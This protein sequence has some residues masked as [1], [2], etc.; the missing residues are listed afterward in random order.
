MDTTVITTGDD[1]PE[2]IDEAAPIVIEAPT[3][4]EIAADL[5]RTVAIIDAQAEA[6]VATIEAEG[7]A[8]VAIIEA[9]A[10]A[11]DELGELR[12]RCEQLEA[13]QAGLNSTLSQMSTTLAEMSARM[14]PAPQQPSETQQTPPAPDAS[15]APTVP[16]EAPGDGGP[17][18]DLA[19]AGQAVEGSSQRLRRYVIR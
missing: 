7:E 12:A 5:E 10:P 6:E 16:G 1:P 15:N 19:A 4:A 3:E 14:Q 8:A 9:A 17:A 13:N 11:A 2:P 18:A